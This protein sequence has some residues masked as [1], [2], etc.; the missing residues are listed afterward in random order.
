[1]Q[2]MNKY[3]KEDKVTFKLELG[4]KFFFITDDKTP[5]PA[6]K[7]TSS[8]PHIFHILLR[9]PYLQICSSSYLSSLINDRKVLQLLRCNPFMIFAFT[10]SL[11]IL[12]FIHIFL[13]S[14][15]VVSLF[16]A[17]VLLLLYSSFF[18]FKLFEDRDHLFTDFCVFHRA[19]QS[20]DAQFINLFALELSWIL[21]KGNKIRTYMCIYTYT[22]T[23]RLLHMRTFSVKMTDGVEL[24]HNYKLSKALYFI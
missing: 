23:E 8:K 13:F 22:K 10:L 11:H 12:A 9:L 1:M 14:Y 16:Q 4:R 19:F 24:T 18:W 2:T 7:S 17:L 5:Y 3:Q 21:S 6:S 15:F 20:K